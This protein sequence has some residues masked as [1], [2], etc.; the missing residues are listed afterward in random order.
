M[1]VP[2][3]YVRPRKI[4]RG[5][6]AE[7]MATLTSPLAV[8]SAAGTTAAPLN[9]YKKC[10]ATRRP[11]GSGDEPFLDD[12]FTNSSESEPKVCNAEPLFQICMGNLPQPDMQQKVVA[13]F[14]VRVVKSMLDQRTASIPAVCLESLPQL[15]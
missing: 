4:H 15:I 8:Q 5:A 9:E 6:F 10:F 14:I 13:S 7:F 12:K 2:G 3:G 1:G 11:L